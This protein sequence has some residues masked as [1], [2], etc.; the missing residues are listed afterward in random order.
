MKHND[1]PVGSQIEDAA[2]EDGILQKA[3]ENAEAYMGSLLMGLGFEQVTFI[4]GTPTP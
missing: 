4:K 3:Q 1:R 2:L